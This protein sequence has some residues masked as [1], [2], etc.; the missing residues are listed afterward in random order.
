[1]SLGIHSRTRGV[2]HRGA[3]A[4]LVQY[5]A[6][7]A[8]TYLGSTWRALRPV[9]GVA[10]VEGADWTVLASAGSSG[11]SELASAVLATSQSSTSATFADVVGMVVAP[12]TVD[13]IMLWI[14]LAY[15]LGR[16]G[17][18]DPAANPRLFIQ[19]LDDLGNAFLGA[20]GRGIGV[21]TIAGTGTLQGQASFPLRITPAS[22]ART[23]K[24]QMKVNA[25]SVASTLWG[26]DL[27]AG[28]P[29]TLRAV[30]R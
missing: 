12:A 27:V 2:R 25:T 21:P 20:G 24:L 15:Q 1:M 14:D 4:A 10:P 30:R 16:N 5:Y 11:S 22:V 23:Y 6:Y 18:P 7:D 8:V 9:L 29:T 17:A 26:S 3:Y 28:V 19:I 13:P